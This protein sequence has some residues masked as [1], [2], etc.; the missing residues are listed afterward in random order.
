LEGG[1]VKR[2]LILCLLVLVSCDKLKS[3]KSRQD[4]PAEQPTSQTLLEARQGFHTKLLK[5]EKENEPVETPPANLMKVVQYPSPAGNLAAYLTNI[6]QDGKKHPAIIWIFGGFG[7]GIGDTAWKRAD[8]NNDQSASA[9][10][11]AG[12]VTMYP[13]LRGGNQNPGVQESF[14]GE[15]DDV[16]AAADFLA[17]QPGIDPSR[18]YLGGHSTGGTL[19]LLVAETGARKFRAIFCF[20][21]VGNV[22]GYGSDSLVFDADDER[23]L[24][25]RA[26]IRFLK[27]IAV[28]T[29]VLEGGSG[30]SNASELIAMS[31]K[32]HSN[33]VQFYSV[34]QADHF[35]ILYPVTRLLAARIS[36]DTGAEVNID[37]EQNDLNRL[38]YPPRRSR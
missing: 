30:S 16:L 4:S 32:K 15:V 7:N 23:E 29:W 25:V 5:Q 17:A 1:I 2:I 11:E 6:P 31:Q 20:G 18:I 10:R 24:E 26:P 35:S 34:N 38:R 12:I 14:Y 37:I 13:S 9:F 21:P 33:Q 27:A 8:Q 22:A 19:A 28:P 36:A 3:S